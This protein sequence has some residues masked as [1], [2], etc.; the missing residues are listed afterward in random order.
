M[1]IIHDGGEVKL[2]SKEWINKSSGRGDTELIVNDGTTTK[3]YSYSYWFPF[4]PY[5]EVFP[6]LF[7]W[8][9]FSAD[10]EFFKENDEYF[11][12]EYH[13]HYD[14]EDDEWL[15]VGDTF[16]EYRKKLSPMRSIDHSGE[17]AE[18]M[19]KLSLNELGKSFLNIDNF[20]SQ[21]QPYTDTRPKG[22]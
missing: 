4:T 10:E 17:V 5:K 7:P 13:C 1:Q 15:I 20:V 6:R 3:N 12:R 9:D 14:E 8:A 11:W 18:Y 16:E 22:E 21:N 2:H 19:M